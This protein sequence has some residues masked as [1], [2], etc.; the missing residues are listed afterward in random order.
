MKHSSSRSRWALALSILVCLSVPAFAFLV[1][2]APADL[3]KTADEMMQKVVGI[4]GL[5]PTGPVQKGVKTRKE[6]SEYLDQRVHSTYDEGE[7]QGEGKMLQKLGLI[8]A[9]M[10]YKDFMIKLLTEQIGGYYD[11]EKKTFFIA[12]WLSLDEQR[13]VMVHELTHALQDQH[14][15]LEHLLAADRK[16]QDDDRLLA[17]LALFEGDATGVML[18]YLLAP[19]GRNFSQLPN[20]VFVMRAQ[21]TTMETQ[22]EIFRQA[23]A[24]LKETLVFPY[25][26]GAAFLQKVRADHPW[27][28]VDKIYADLPS[29]TE[30]IIHPEKYL[31]KRDNPI[32]VDEKD[33]SS[34]LGADWR[35]SY[36][37]VLG[38]FTFYLMFKDQLSE[39]QS[40]AAS[41]GWGGDKVFL[42]ENKNG[43][44]AVWGFTVWDTPEDATEFSGALGDWLQHRFP[45]SQRADESD[46]AFAVIHSGDYDLVRRQG[47]KV[48][49][50]I[51]LPE[52]E[53]SKLK[54]A[55]PAGPQRD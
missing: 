36:T 27:A 50:V 12:G 25:S 45:K 44:S 22:F 24:Y 21:F 19:A 54:S 13:P 6:I 42:V 17:H 37:N 31:D 5:E 49:Y 10:N 26:Y 43:A 18:D 55:S 34:R 51:G 15:D 2:T 35:A 7:L 53:S 41:S 48:E 28:A 47:T 3:L 20:L 23:P 1:Q 14:F 46:S 40:K 30:Q 11:P 32:P 52:S 8:P 38:E 33:P 4:R 29:S 9:T 39:A 16:L